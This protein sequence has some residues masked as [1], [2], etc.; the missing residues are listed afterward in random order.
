[1]RRNRCLILIILF[2]GR[3]STNEL[4]V[5]QKKK[6]VNKSHYLD[7]VVIVFVFS[8]RKSDRPNEYSPVVEDPPGRRLLMDGG[9]AH[10]HQL[11]RTPLPGITWI[12]EALG[13]R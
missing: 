13:L 1:M 11:W 8:G 6:K 9:K 2:F 7:S 3:S 12:V 4:G 10:L 5:K